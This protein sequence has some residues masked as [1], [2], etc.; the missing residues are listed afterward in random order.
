[1]SNPF[2]GEIRMFGG[3]FAP[4]GW[5][6]CAGQLLAISENATLFNLIG[7]TYGGDGQQTFALPDLSGRIP[8]HQG[9]GA[10]LGNYVIGEKSGVESVTLTLNQ[11]PAHSHSVLAST[12][13]GSASNPLNVVLA[14]P[15]SVT[16]F[17]A[18][19]PSVVLPS[20]LVTVSGGSQPHDNL[21]PYVA[22]NY[23][24]SLFGIYPSQN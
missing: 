17:I 8:L 6:F 2:V 11:I 15:P 19:D 10:G 12:A 23:I 20:N 16:A 24:I 21:M 3:N 18:D 7:T 1:M 22:V 5:A 13:G 14:N 9:Q 4:Q